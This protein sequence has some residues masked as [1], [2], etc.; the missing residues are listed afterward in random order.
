M[1]NAKNDLYYIRKLREDLTFIVAHGK[2]EMAEYEGNADEEYYMHLDDFHKLKM[3]MS[4]SEMKQIADKGFPFLQTM[5]SISEEICE[6]F[7]ADIK[8][9]RL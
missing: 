8:K 4:P 9:K 6:K 7:I 1:D 5:Y 2:L 3:P